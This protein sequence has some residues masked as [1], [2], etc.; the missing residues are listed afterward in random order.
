MYIWA[1]IILNYLFTQ[2]TLQIVFDDLPMNS[3]YF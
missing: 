1:L 2:Y 3:F